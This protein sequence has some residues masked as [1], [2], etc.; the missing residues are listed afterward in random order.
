MSQVLFYAVTASQYAGIT[1]KNPD[2]IYFITDGN[3]I[4]KGVV[5]YTH[6]V[7]AVSSFPTSGQV[8]TLYI[9]K[10]TFEAKTWN[11]TAWEVV[12][13]PVITSIGTSPTNAQIPTAQAVKNYVDAEI[14]NVNAGL[15]G[16]VSNVNYNPNTK[17][18]SVQK[19]AGEAVVTALSGLFDSVSYNGATGV[20]SFTTNG[21][22]A[23][24]VNLPVEQFLAAAAYDEATHTLT[25]T[26]TDNSKFEVDLA[27]LI[28]TY[29]GGESATAEV[30]IANGAVTANVKL[31]AEVS[32]LVEAK[33]DG[34]FVAPLAWQTL[35]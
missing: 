2:A 19:G 20:L 6:P 29:T 18:I 12:S 21:G 27:D 28:D 25:L 3:R 26:M 33:A 1:T 17:S 10:T 16:A 35:A 7:E 31:S 32:N 8:G 30:E 14:V 15:S 13:L 22:T 4:Y 24:T 5:P 23:Q 9:H 34:I 11:G